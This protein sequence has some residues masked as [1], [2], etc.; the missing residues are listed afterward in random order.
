MLWG[1]R[2]GTA[3][4]SWFKYKILFPIINQASDRADVPYSISNSILLGSKLQRHTQ[5]KVKPV[6]S[7]DALHLQHTIQKRGVTN[8]GRCAKEQENANKYLENDIS[9]RGTNLQH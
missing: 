1:N 8:R 5:C 7:A 9:K 3:N 6:I 2:K 4:E